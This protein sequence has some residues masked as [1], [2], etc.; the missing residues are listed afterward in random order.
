MILVEFVPNIYLGDLYFSG[1][2][3]MPET[4]WEKHLEDVEKITATGSAINLYDDFFL[5][6][7]D[8]YMNMYRVKTISD[9]D[10]GLLIQ[11]FGPRV[12]TCGV[13]AFLVAKL[14]TVNMEDLCESVL[15]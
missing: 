5:T 2:I 14:D 11:L 7:I 13:G 10:T 6:S 1:F 3:L 15:H 4:H 9:D 8:A 12:V